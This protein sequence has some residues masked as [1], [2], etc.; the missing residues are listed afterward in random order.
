MRSFMARFAD[1]RERG[2]GRGGGQP[3]GERAAG[4][5]PA[6]EADLAPVRFDRALDETQAEPVAVDPGGHR[7]GAAEEGLE[8]PP[9]LGRRDADAPVFDRDDDL[10]APGPGPRPDADPAR[11]AGVLHGVAEE[12][13]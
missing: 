7:V 6:V 11:L 2:L 10:A 12:V 5:R 4:P 8:D 9:R 1:R 13:A 3:D